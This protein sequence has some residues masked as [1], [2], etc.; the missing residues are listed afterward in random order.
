MNDGGGFQPATEQI[1]QKAKAEAE[2][3]SLK[4]LG[5]RPGTRLSLRLGVE[6]KGLGSRDLRLTAA[7]ASTYFRLT[8]VTPSPPSARSPGRKDET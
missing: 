2:Q 5:S 1:H 6:R 3:E 7:L 8:I 4:K